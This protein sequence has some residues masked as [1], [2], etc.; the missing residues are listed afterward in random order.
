VQI[1]DTHLHKPVKD[2][3]RK[4]AN[5]WYYDKSRKFYKQWKD[6]KIT[7]LEFHEKIKSLMGMRMLKELALRWLWAAT[8]N[9]LNILPGKASYRFFFLLRVRNSVCHWSY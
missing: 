5:G 2:H 6:G 3:H 1:N 7:E 9:L 4:N 8:K